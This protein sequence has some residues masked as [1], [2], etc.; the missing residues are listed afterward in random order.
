MAVLAAFS[1]SA[2]QSDSGYVNPLQGDIGVHDPVIMRQ[3]SMYYIFHTGGGVSIKRSPDRINWSEGEPSR[4]IASN[5]S[6]HDKYS[7]SG[8][9]W[10]PAI[11]R[12]GGKY[13]LYYSMS[14]FGSRRSAIGLRTNVTLHQ[15]DPE[16][17]W[18]DEG[19]V[20]CTYDNAETHPECFHASTQSVN[21]ND[22]NAF[23]AIDPD[24]YIDSAGT[25]WLSWGSFGSGIKMLRLNPETGKPD[26]GAQ[27]YTPVHRYN[28]EA[29]NGSGY[30]RSIEAPV[31]HKRGDWYYLWFSHDRCCAGSNSTYKIKVA[32]SASVT[33]SYFDRD[34][35]MAHPPYYSQSGG[36]SWQTANAGTL[37]SEGDG[38]WAATG[39]ND[40]FVD[41]DTT[42]LVNHAYPREGGGSR[43]MI[44]T[45][46]WDPAGWP[47]LDSTQGVAVDPSV[48]V[49]SGTQRIFVPRG[50]PIQREGGNLL[51][52]WENGPRDLLGRDPGR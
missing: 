32:R 15:D 22:T 43:L 52:P 31:I 9:L 7:T 16:Y 14:N 13:W 39:H 17:E 49:R 37:V 36:G 4:V 48:P 40:I 10:A 25:P 33:G 6:W 45:L 27:L 21:S 24:V 2:A 3:D 5:P 42:F 11:S 46:Y 41:N 51:V 19:M 38:I 26:S 29:E 20:V 50:A 28:P 8:S 1:L 35:N 44:R 12:W 18:V 34:G 47:S 30:Y 23:N